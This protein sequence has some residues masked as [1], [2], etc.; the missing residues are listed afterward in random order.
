MQNGGTMSSL[1]FSYWSSPHTSTKSGLKSSRI[2]RI[3]R[4]S[5]PKRS[6]QRCA[7]ESPSSLPSSA[8][9]SEGQLAGSLTA[10][11]TF[12]ASSTRLNTSVRRSFGRHKVGQWVQPSPRISAIFVP[13]LSCFVRIEK[14]IQ[15]GLGHE[16]LTA[17]GQHHPGLFAA[18]PEMRGRPEPRGFVERA[19][20]NPADH[21]PGRCARLRTAGK[22]ATAFGTN[23]SCHNMTAICGFLQEPRLSFHQTKRTVRYRY[24][25]REGAAGQALTIGA[26]A[27]I[28]HQRDLADLIPQRAAQAAAG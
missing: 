17:L 14:P 10:G 26:V 21:L 19:G 13:P 27:G 24:R 9:N 11:L 18:R 15:I 23:P 28:G 3:A 22:P 16:D 5:L 12:G 25:E 2:L 4:K 7:A 6:P 20:A 8:S 1:K